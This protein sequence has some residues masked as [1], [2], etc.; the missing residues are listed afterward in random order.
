MR[1]RSDSLPTRMPTSVSG[2]GD[3]VSELHAGEMYAGRSLVRGSTR[4]VDRVRDSGDV[5]D[6][7]AVRH[8]PPVVQRG[9]GV[10]DERAGC[11]RLADAL[12][13]RAAVPTRWI[14]AACE[15]DR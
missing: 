5:E 14:L 12:D 15:H 10:E 11:F 3:V 9:T 1:S 4:G 8:E 6:P 13:G 7:A 2:M